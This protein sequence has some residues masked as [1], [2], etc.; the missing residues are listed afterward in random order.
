MHRFSYIQVFYN[1][2]THIL[3]KI[4]LANLHN[5]NGLLILVHLLTTKPP[6]LIL[7]SFSPSLSTLHTLSHSLM[8]LLI[9][10]FCNKVLPLL[11]VGYQLRHGG[12]H[13]IALVV[14]Q[15][16]N[17]EVLLDSMFLEV[18]INVQLLIHVRNN[19]CAKLTTF[20][21]NNSVFPENWAGSQTP[22]NSSI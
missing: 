12:C 15:F 9:E 7:S 20:F 4:V 16:S 13:Q 14:Q 21:L 18:N 1:H 2:F 19:T 3:L 5:W 10:L 17:S 11:D 8:S 6:V 22:A